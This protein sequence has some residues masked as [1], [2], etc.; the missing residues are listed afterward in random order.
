MIGSPRYF[1]RRMW[2]GDYWPEHGADFV[3]SNPSFF[4]ISDGDT[5]SALL[6]YLQQYY[7]DSTHDLAT[8]LA[9][10]LQEGTDEDSTRQWKLLYD[11]IKVPTT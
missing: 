11:A 3:P 1:S 7:S 5:N 4:D 10:F 6:L 2:T 8:L 9:R